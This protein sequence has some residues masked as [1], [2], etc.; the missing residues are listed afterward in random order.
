M[1]RL[2]DVNV[3]VALA[4]PNHMHHGRALQWFS[5]IDEEGWATCP[6]TESGFVR[7]SS[8]VR[9]IPDARTPGQAIELLRQIRDLPGHCFWSDDVSPADPDAPAFERV[10]GYRQVTDAHLLTLALRKGG[11]LATFDRG[12]TELLPGT[13][14]AVELIP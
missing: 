2:L 9:V 11:V 8:N 5:S 7:V 14:D 3:L 10:V 12:V 1:T 4:W 6:V 13:P